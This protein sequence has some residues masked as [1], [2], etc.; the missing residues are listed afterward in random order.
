MNIHTLEPES[1]VVEDR[2]DEIEPLSAG[3]GKCNHCACLQYYDRGP[4]FSG[5]C[6]CGHSIGT[7]G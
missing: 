5:T 4:G 1:K 6:T 3:Y 2:D 7:H